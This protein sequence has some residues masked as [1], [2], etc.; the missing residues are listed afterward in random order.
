[1]S[2]FVGRGMAA[3]YVSEGFNFPEDLPEVYWP[4]GVRLDF[5]VPIIVAN[6][7]SYILTGALISQVRPPEPKRARGEK[8]RAV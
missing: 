3:P 4:P 6:S 1:M 7:F 8:G 2:S 5:L